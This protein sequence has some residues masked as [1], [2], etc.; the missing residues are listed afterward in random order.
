MKP[1]TKRLWKHSVAASVVA[2]FLSLFGYASNHSGLSGGVFL[3]VPFCTGLAIAFMSKGRMIVAITAMTSLLLSLSILVFSGWEGMGCVVMALP[4]L[5]LGIGLGAA[6]GYF[7]GKKFIHQYGNITV[8]AVCLGLMSLVGW[9]NSEKAEPEVLVVRTSM[10]FHAPM[11]AVWSSVIESGTLEGDDTALRLLGLPVPN[12][13]TL[14]EDGTR[15]CYFESGTMI[16]NVKS[17]IYGVSFEVEIVES[18]EV[19]DWISFIDAGYEFTQHEG[20]VQV[21]RTDR[22][23]STLRPR[24]YWH[25]FEE[26]CVQLEH[27]YVMTSM[28]NKAEQGRTRQNKAE[29]GRTRQNKTRMTKSLPL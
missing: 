25:W 21:V 14:S 7:I 16:Q 9:T 11:S 10:I 20:Y 19:R 2:V 18:L 8:V 24:W 27:Q 22:I 17:A 29:Q 3:L 13:C 23:E 12:S 6:V 15:V 4:I 5:F 28:K 1:E 26:E